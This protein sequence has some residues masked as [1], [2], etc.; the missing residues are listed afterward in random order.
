MGLFGSDKKKS[1]EQLRTLSEKEIQDKLYGPF[2]T[3][4][5]VV[6][7]E[8]AVKQPQ[9]AAKP[10]TSV[11]STHV[12]SRDLFKSS[13]LTKPESSSHLSTFRPEPTEKNRDNISSS[14]F[15]GDAAADSKSFSNRPKIEAR[16]KSEVRQGPSVVSRLGTASMHFVRVL[17]NGIFSVLR[18][19]IHLVARLIAVIDLRNARVRTGAY[20]AGGILLLAGLLFSIHN[21]NVKREAA[22][23]AP[24]KKVE[25]PAFFGIK[26]KEAKKA[27]DVSPNEESAS[28]L[29]PSVSV[30]D[31]GKLGADDL[32]P[33]P[34]T[35]TVVSKGTHVIQV[36]TF[37]TEDDARRL[38]SKVKES[39][40]VSF[41]KPLT[42]S[43]GKVYYCV[44]IGRFASSQ[45]AE[46]NL[47]QFKKKE[48]SR[49]FQDAFVRTL[50]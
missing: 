49:S 6:R 30:S 47:E 22:M 2:R 19:I 28:P 45:E 24:R 39:G 23:K 5:S 26:K 7:D 37:A 27:V 14:R 43:T 17:G 34:K 8:Y 25:A 18:S 9:V 21:L 29:S 32:L 33:A 48:V 46:T 4:S 12:E 41:V 13:T 44:F 11:T 20:W 10:T 50:D 3:S 40:M 16:I 15:G 1:G 38:S 42:R 31:T 35:Q 36:A